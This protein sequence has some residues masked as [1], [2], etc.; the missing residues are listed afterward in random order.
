MYDKHHYFDLNAEAIYDV[1][2]NHLGDLMQT[3]KKM[4]DDL[5]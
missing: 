5:K 1:C 3:I 2:E 4:I